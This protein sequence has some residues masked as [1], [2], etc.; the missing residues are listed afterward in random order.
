VLVDVVGDNVVVDEFVSFVVVVSF[1]I[2][3]SSN[4]SL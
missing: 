2:Y 4:N 1:L 3:Y